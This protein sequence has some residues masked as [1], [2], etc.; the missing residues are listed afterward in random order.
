ME[1]WLHIVCRFGQGA[2]TCKHLTFGKDGFQ[3]AKADPSLRA[4]IEAILHLTIYTAQGDNC[5][6]IFDQNKLNNNPR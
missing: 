1:N 6:G 4:G 2:Q 3:C 5:H